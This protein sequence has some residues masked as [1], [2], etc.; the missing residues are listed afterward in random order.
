MCCFASIGIAAEQQKL[1]AGFIALSDSEMNWADAKAWCRQQGG[2][3]PRFN[4]S[5]SL[6]NVPAGA[7]IDGFGKLGA[8]WP[9]GL[10]KGIFWTGT[11]LSDLPDYTYAVTDFG[12]GLVTNGF[13]QSVTRRVVCV[14]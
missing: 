4:Y 13:R 9:A 5:D 14:P 12:G 3:L 7:V 6:E 11:V 8:S 10:P 1:P 2:I